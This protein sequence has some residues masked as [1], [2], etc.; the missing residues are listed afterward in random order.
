MGGVGALVRCGVE[1]VRQFAVGFAAGVLANLFTVWLLLGAGSK[2]LSAEKQ[3]KL[4]AVD[5]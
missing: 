4:R 3:E 5:P 1:T 2:I